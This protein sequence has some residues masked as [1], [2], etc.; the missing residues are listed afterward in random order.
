MQIGNDAYA[1]G[2]V[3]FSR[4]AVKARANQFADAMAEDLFGLA[5]HRMYWPNG[6]QDDDTMQQRWKN[7]K[8]GSTIMHVRQE[9]GGDS[10]LKWMTSQLA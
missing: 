10:D 1:Q 4:D 7:S 6:L 8:I 9:P 3:D 2:Q 5:E